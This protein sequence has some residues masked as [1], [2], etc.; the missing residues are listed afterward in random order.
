[1]KPDNATPLM[2][3]DTVAKSDEFTGP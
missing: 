1:M 3:A 2:I